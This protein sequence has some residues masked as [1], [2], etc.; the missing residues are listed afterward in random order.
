MHKTGCVELFVIRPG[1]QDSVIDSGSSRQKTLLHSRRQGGKITR[2]R[3]A[4]TRNLLRVASPFPGMRTARDRYSLL[5]KAD[6]RY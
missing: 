6:D 5:T 3:Y 1:R 2:K 4:A